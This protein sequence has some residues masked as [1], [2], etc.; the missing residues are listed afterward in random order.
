MKQINIADYQK[1]LISI[2]LNRVSSN[3]K[4]Y[5]GA[6]FTLIP[7]DEFDKLHIYV[8]IILRNVFFP[9]LHNSIFF[10]KNL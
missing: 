4:V 9:A 10:C 2:L 8:A 7:E 5:S 3:F 1:Y 6:G